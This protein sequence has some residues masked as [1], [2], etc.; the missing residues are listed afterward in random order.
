MN[1]HVKRSKKTSGPRRARKCVNG[2]AQV[3]A[4]V[5]ELLD[6]RHNRKVLMDALRRG[7]MADPLQFFHVIIK[8]LLVRD[9][10]LT[11]SRNGVDD[12]VIEWKSLFD[13]PLGPPKD[14]R[15]DGEVTP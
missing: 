15:P 9:A 8:P 14:R 13:A 3:V 12:G 10:R 6:N 1:T 2:R 7:L 4:M 11:L 5:D